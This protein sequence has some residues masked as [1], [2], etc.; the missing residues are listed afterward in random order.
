MEYANRRLAN[1]EYIKPNTGL[2]KQRQKVP[3]NEDIDMD[4]IVKDNMPRYAIKR[5]L[6]EVLH[7]RKIATETERQL[8]VPQVMQDAVRM[9]FLLVPRCALLFGE[10]L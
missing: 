7:D 5:D 8:K 1:I 10:S 9:V 3:D 4:K 6:K 2:R